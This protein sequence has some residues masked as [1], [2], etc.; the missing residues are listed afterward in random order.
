M[1]RSLSHSFKCARAVLCFLLA[2]LVFPALIWFWH[3][4]VWHVWKGVFQAL[5][6]MLLLFSPF[7]FGGRLGR[8]WLLVF[9]ALYV[10]VS[11]FQ[12]HHIFLYGV[13]VSAQ[14]F[15][16]LA[17]TNTME[18]LEFAGST[19]SFALLAVVLAAL[20]L[21]LLPLRALW[22]LSAEFGFHARMTAV[23]LIAAALILTFVRSPERM[24]RHDPLWTVGAQY[25]LFDRS[26]AELR[27][28]PK[29][30]P[31]L[32]AGY[33]IAS[34][35]D[36][37]LTLVVVVGESASRRHHGYYGYPRATT[38][39]MGKRL[40]NMILFSDI[41]SP[42][43]FTAVSHKRVFLMP[44]ETG[45][46]RP[47]LP[48]MHMLNAAGAETWWISTQYAYASTN[49]PLTLTADHVVS[50]NTLEDKRQ[51][52]DEAV[53]EELRK[54]LASSAEKT[55]VVFI[56]IMGSHAIY[57]SRYPEEFSFFEGK[58]DMISRFADDEKARREI[59]AYD[60]SIR[61]TDHILDGIAEQLEKVPNGALLYLSDHGQDVYD[62]EKKG[63]HSPKHAVGVEIPFFLWMTG[64]SGG[65]GLA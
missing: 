14:T 5:P 10:S 21:P 65:T 11:I 28:L 2:L 33:N 15:A 31:A 64:E 34:R 4:P 46:E 39:Q 40:E 32:F 52:Y 37:P 23:I 61:Y 50:I 42:E 16:A 62:V 57:D 22:K 30:D 27:L 24:W 19:F 47:P 35:D 12:S 13:P 59:N 38:P 29:K 20:V 36:T 43:A 54:V 1:A 6:L 9:Y 26:R 25:A 58:E 63:G 44:S 49:S 3:F 53:L 56:N 17:E 48:L 18:A 51:F 8:V 60:N 7:F 45:P 55:R 41:I